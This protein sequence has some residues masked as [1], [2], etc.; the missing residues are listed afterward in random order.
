MNCWCSLI[1]FVFRVRR[2]MNWKDMCVLFLIEL[3]W[4]CGVGF[5]KFKILFGGIIILVYLVLR[6]FE[7][8]GYVVCF[9]VY[10]VG[11]GL[12]YFGLCY[13]VYGRDLLL[14][15]WWGWIEGDDD[16]ICVLY[17][18]DLYVFY[19]GCKVYFRKFIC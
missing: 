15:G 16:V 6:F 4:L 1:L 3:W 8:Y 12:S 11:M 9:Y 13:L 19:R 14:F 2:D 17:G 10:I 5:L 18:V 7:V